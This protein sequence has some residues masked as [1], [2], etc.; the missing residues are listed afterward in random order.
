MD[1][2]ILSELTKLKDN[3]SNIKDNIKTDLV[4]IAQSILD[5]V[6]I[7]TYKFTDEEKEVKQKIEELMEFITC[8]FDEFYQYDEEDLDK[9]IV[10]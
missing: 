5:K 8:I 10:K 7:N 1:S 4:S 6:D 3:I 2:Q 9:L